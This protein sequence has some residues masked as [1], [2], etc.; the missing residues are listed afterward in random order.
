[1]QDLPPTGRTGGRPDSDEQIIAAL[2][3][4]PVSGGTD[5]HAAD[6]LLLRAVDPQVAAAYERVAHR[7]DGW[8]YE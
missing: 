5:H 8:W 3:A 2:D 7:A 6:A 4:L 1:M